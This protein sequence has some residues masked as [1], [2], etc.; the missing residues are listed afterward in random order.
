MDGRRSRCQ[1]QSR[2]R[3]LRARGSHAHDRPPGGRIGPPRRSDRPIRAGQV[4]VGGQRRSP[5][6]GPLHDPSALGGRSRRRSPRRPT[7]PVW[8]RTSSYARCCRG[9]DSPWPTPMPRGTEHWKSETSRRTTSVRPQTRPGEPRPQP[10]PTV[11]G[12]GDLGRPPPGQRARVK[13]SNIDQPLTWG[14]KPSENRLLELRRGVRRSPIGAFRVGVPP[15]PPHLAWGLAVRPD[16]WPRDDLGHLRNK[17]GPESTEA[18][19]ARRR[20]QSVRDRSHAFH[21]F[22]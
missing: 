18:T 6:A 2:C 9:Y 4:G 12:A 17:E 21:R 15:R 11:A 16:S 1:L 13:S 22:R 3:P 19:D 10:R 8:R 5:R 7:R 14:Y 20:H